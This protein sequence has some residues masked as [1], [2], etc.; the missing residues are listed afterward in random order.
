MPVAIL[1]LVWALQE[2]RSRLWRYVFFVDYLVS[3]AL[4]VANSLDLL[5]SDLRRFDWG[6]YSVGTHYY[7]AFSFFLVANLLLTSILLVHDYRT[8]TEPRRRVQL[9]FWLFGAVVAFPLGLTNLLPAYGVPVYPLGNLGS[10][11]WAAIVAY[12]IAR[13]RMMDIDIV[14]TKGMAYTAVAFVL[15]VPAFLTLLWL[16]RLSFGQIHPDFS[17]AILAMLITV[18]VLFPALRLQAESRI[19]RSLFREKHEYRA[20]LTDFTR[21]IVR[22]LEREKLITTLV[23]TL[24]RTLRVDHIAISMADEA[25]RSFTVVHATG[26]PAATAPFPEAHGFI[27][28]LIR[29]QEVVLQDEFESGADGVDAEVAFNVCRENGWEVCIPLMIG[30]KLIGFIGIGRKH[31]LDAFSAEDLELLGT[32]AAEASVAL[33][34][35]RLYEELKRSHDLIRRADRLSALGTLAAGIAHEV[36]NP[37][38]AIQTFFQLAPERLHDE[39]FFTTFLTMTA[40]EVKRIADLITELLS[41][42]RSPTPSLGPVNLSEIADRVITLLEPEARKH[43]I[44]LHRM[45]A[46]DGPIVRADG[47]QIKQVLINLVLN[48]LQATAP[49]GTVSVT[50]SSV[51]HGSVTLGQLEVRDTG[52]GISPEQLDHIFNPFFTTKDKGT[53]LGLAIA[54]QVISEHGGSISVE[55]VEGRGTQFLVHLPLFEQGFSTDPPQGRPT[56]FVGSPQRQDRLR[57]VS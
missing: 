38:V 39:E 35:A 43:K 19:E 48:A 57:K 17:F 23:D 31:N 46:G 1:H 34:N 11:V 33:E 5:V 22:I 21:S 50:T 3:C 24:G 53:G 18:G 4:T 52:T 28:S 51:Q 13:H 56:Y 14:V 20:A 30:G 49:E 45:L 27:Q 47:D 25:T 2:S 26:A 9:Q 8:T 12:A 32:L 42:A 16:Q 44:E 40:S 54:H 41:F 55:S 6:F 29:R 37:L 15:I 7:R 36:R 10:A